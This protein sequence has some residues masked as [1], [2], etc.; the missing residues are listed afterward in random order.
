MLWEHKGSLWCVRVSLTP[1]C[2]ARPIK[3]ILHS[4]LGRLAQLC[5]LACG[6]LDL[7]VRQ[8]LS[9]FITRSALLVVVA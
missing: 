5:L 9:F 6:C 4:W 2:H 1:P 7:L 8:G 3:T